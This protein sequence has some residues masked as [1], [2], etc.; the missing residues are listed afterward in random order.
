MFHEEPFHEKQ[1]RS[2]NV[3]THLAATALGIYKKKQDGVT[4]QGR[5][6]R[7]HNVTETQAQQP[8]LAL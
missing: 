1:S 2:R 5:L 8:M 6:R 7:R 4:Y 3:S